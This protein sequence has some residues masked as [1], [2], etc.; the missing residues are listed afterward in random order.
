MRKVILVVNTTLDGY[1]AG[2]NGELDWMVHDPRVHAEA[3][4]ELRDRSECV[5]VDHVG[6]ARASASLCQCGS[7]E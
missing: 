4:I 3:W 5:H 1:M 2:P 7:L 6:P